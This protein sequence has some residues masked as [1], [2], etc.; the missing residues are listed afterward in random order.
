[1]DNLDIEIEDLKKVKDINKARVFIYVFF[2]MLNYRYDEFQRFN[3]FTN[4]KSILMRVICDVIDSYD[5]HYNSHIKNAVEITDSII[6]NENNF[7]WL[8]D[9]KH[10]V[11]YLWSEINQLNLIKDY[12]QRVLLTRNITEIKNALNINWSLSGDNVNTDTIKFIFNLIDMNN[13]QKVDF[14]NNIKYYFNNAR[15]SL[16]EI[17]WLSLDNK[18]IC[19]WAWEYI[20]KYNQKEQ[21]EY[22]RNAGVYSICY[23]DPLND[24]EKYFAI[25]ASLSTWYCH[26]SEKTLFLKNI[27]KAYKQREFR[28]KR[29]NKKTLSCILDTD[30]KTHLEELAETYEMTI[31]DLVTRL[32]ENEYRT[33]KK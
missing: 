7:N 11:Y 8:K 30:V 9:N 23:F 17:S 21:Q 18:H 26:H 27:T 29:E 31:T 3:F 33:P 15:N 10:A 25:H 1:M 16:G 2:E 20:K 14:V 4:D 12:N 5:N 24:E 19:S 13:S 32:I 22:G 28:E 6:I